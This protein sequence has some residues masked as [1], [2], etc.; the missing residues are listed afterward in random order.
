MRLFDLAAVIVIHK[1]GWHGHSHG[2]VE[3]D[4]VMEEG[5]EEEER[6]K[7]RRTEIRVGGSCRNLHHPC[8]EWKEWK[9][10]KGLTSV[11]WPNEKRVGR[12]LEDTPKTTFQACHARQESE[13][14]R[15]G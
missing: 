11:R 14:C 7:G 8:Q 6:T 2:F 5:E 9:E 15:S 1:D 12:T 13:R 4:C 3:E 10:W